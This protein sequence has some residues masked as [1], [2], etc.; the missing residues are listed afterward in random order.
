M[1]TRLLIAVASLS[2]LVAPAAAL[3]SHGG[4]SKSSDGKGQVAYELKG[5]LSAFS[6]VNGSSPGSITIM[7]TGGN[8]AGRAFV[9]DTLTFM[10]TKATR[11]ET[12]DNGTIANG[13]PGEIQVKG[14]A[15]LDAAGLQKLIP[16]KVEDEAEKE[17]NG[18]NPDNHGDRGDHGS[19]GDH[20][21][22]G[23]D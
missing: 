10:L 23:D 11:V 14:A 3:A 22:H 12:N 19:L 20:G 16:R 17:D 4:K 6:P 5:K 21:G 1:R 15:G 2:L 13:D 8:K 9:G 18:Q 7:V